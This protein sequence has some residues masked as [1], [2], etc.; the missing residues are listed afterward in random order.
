VRVKLELLLRRKPGAAEAPFPRIDGTAF[1]RA[2]GTRVASEWSGYGS[3]P[4]RETHYFELAGPGSGNFEVRIGDRTWSLPFD[5]EKPKPLE[6]VL[7]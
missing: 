1:V 6:I 3:Y 4:G 5:A 2:D 7:D